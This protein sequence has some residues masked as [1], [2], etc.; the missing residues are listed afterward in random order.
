MSRT[1][2]REGSLWQLRYALDE[3]NASPNEDRLRFMLRSI[4]PKKGSLE[5]LLRLEHAS[6]MLQCV[7]SE[8]SRCPTLF[9][10]LNKFGR[11]SHHLR[12]KSQLTHTVPQ[13]KSVASTL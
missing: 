4:L 7:R 8:S 2:Q 13:S 1:F 3:T 5:I 11:T 10:W 6:S 9:S 12:R